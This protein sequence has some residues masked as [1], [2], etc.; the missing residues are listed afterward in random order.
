MKGE[1]HALETNGTWELVPRPLKKHIVDCKL[2]LES[3]IIIMVQL[4]KT[5]LG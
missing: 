4:I 1:I 2:F 3:R 5:S